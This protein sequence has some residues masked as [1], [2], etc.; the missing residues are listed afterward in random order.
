[1]SFKTAQRFGVAN[2]SDYAIRPR[3]LSDSKEAKRPAGSSPLPP[4]DLSLTAQK[5]PGQ[6]IENLIGVTSLQLDSRVFY[7]NRGSGIGPNSR[8]NLI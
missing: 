6:V 1:M 7:E 8:T 5:L 3:Q 2:W 4:A